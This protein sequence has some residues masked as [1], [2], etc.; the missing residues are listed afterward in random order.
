MI[1]SFKLYNQK[2]FLGLVYTVTF[3]CITKIDLETG[4]VFKYYSNNLL[5]YNF[6]MRRFLVN[7]KSI[8]L[9]N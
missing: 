6:L 5:S 2:T 7:L 1:E 8:G 4:T 9:M 3:G